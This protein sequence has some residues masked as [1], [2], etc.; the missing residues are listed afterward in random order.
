M[1]N[2]ASPI[3]NREK[4]EKPMAKA[5]PSAKRDRI[6]PFVPALVQYTHDVVYGDLWER[7]GLS[8]RDRSLVTLAAG[9]EG[10]MS[11]DLADLFLGDAVL[12][13]AVEVRGE[14]L[15]PIGRNQSSERH[16]AAVAL[17]APRAFPQIAVHD[18]MGVL[19]QRRNERLDAVALG[20]W[21]GFGHW[22]LSLLSVW[23]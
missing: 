8:K 6:Q 9:I 10:E 4:R 15:G 18:V 20:G 7:P 21:R 22:L 14:L 11:D 12:D 17:R 1:R 5:P 23:N 19:H 2:S 3:P 16:Q 13:R